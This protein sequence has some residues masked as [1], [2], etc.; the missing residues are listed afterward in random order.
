LIEP[1]RRFSTADWIVAGTA[2]FIIGNG[3]SV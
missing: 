2:L 1:L 3:A